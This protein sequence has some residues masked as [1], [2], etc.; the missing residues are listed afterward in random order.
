MSGVDGF[1]A[2]FVRTC[3]SLEAVSFSF[4]YLAKSSW[5]LLTRLEIRAF[6]RGGFARTMREGLAALGVWDAGL[7]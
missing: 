7:F 6:G 1:C 3:R 4:A 2:L 5:S